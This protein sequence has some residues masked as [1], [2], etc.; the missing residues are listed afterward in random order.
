MAAVTDLTFEQL[1]TTMVAN[2]INTN[3]LVLANNR[4]MLD[5]SALIGSNV[6]ALSLPGVVK[7]VVRLL[8]FCV[9]TQNSINE[10]QVLGEKLT[11]FGV[12]SDSIPFDESVPVTHS[13][14]A[15]YKLNSTTQIVG[16]AG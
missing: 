4:V 3:V 12:K 14:T 1:K 16:V 10:Q 11:S 7:L 6:N 15:H 8:H 2:G 5:V 9:K 13:V